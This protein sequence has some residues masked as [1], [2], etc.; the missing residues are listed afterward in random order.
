[1]LRDRLLDEQRVMAVANENLAAVR[2]LVDQGAE[3]NSKDRY[4]LSAIGF[5]PGKEFTDSQSRTEYRER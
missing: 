5:S 1:V 2:A 4:G 3:V